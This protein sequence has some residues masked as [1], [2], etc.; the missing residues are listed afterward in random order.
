MGK[1]P[2]DE[3]ATTSEAKPSR[4]QSEGSPL[5]PPIPMARVLSSALPESRKYQVP[6]PASGLSLRQLSVNAFVL[7]SCNG[8]GQC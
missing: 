5:E 7:S 1:C 4:W 3:A 6:Q 8:G 2:T